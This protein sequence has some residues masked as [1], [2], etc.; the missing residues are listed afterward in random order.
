MSDVQEGY[1]KDSL[2]LDVS[3]KSRYRELEQTL[4]VILHSISEVFEEIE[5]R[6]VVGEFQ[7]RTVTA[8][9]EGSSTVIICVADGSNLEYQFSP[10]KNGKACG[11]PVFQRSNSFTVPASNL[12]N[13]D[14]VVISV[15]S[16]TPAFSGKVLNRKVA[17]NG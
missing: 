6:S 3:W 14:A 8:K 1:S 13:W 11:N 5:S 16:N 9:R 15:R 7:I 10:Q 4:E 12:Q 17:L 2:G